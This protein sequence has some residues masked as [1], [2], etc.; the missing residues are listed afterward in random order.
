MAILI[1]I[2]SISVVI[3]ILSVIIYVIHCINKR[4]KEKIDTEKRRLIIIQERL[5]KINKKNP[6][7]KDLD[8]L[9]KL[10]RDFF[11]NKDNLG[12]NLSYLELAKEFKKNNKK[13]SHFCIKMSELMYSKKEPK[14]KEIKEAINIFSE[15]I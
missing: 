10:A 1:N 7:E 11:K 15:L 4:L 6:G 2:I 3:I 12:Y 13:E 5:D 8:E 9:D 14:E